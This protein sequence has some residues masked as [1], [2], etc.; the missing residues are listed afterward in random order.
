MVNI[1]RLFPGGNTS[2]G[3][4]S[5]HD[6]IIDIDRNMLYILKGMPGG[7]KSTIM[8]E[9][10]EKAVKEGFSVEFHHCPSDP[11]SI[12]GVVINEL[13]ICVLDG[14]APH[15]IDPVYPG[16]TDKIVDLGPF[17]DSD[18]L[19]LYKSEIFMAKKNNKNAYRSAFNYFRSS[20]PIYDNIEQSNKENVDFANINKLTK[21]A[22][23]RIFSK[24]QILNDVVS[25]KERHLF[26][27]AFTPEG[28]VDYTSTVID[29]VKDRYYLNGSIGTGKTTFLK[30]IAQEAILR[31]YHVEIFHNPLIP[32]KIDSLIIKELNTIISTTNDTKNYIYTTI[33]LDEYFD[34]DCI[35]Q[36]DYQL[37]N[38]I[39]EKG[40]DALHSAKDNHA[41]IESVYKKCINYSGI[42][43]IK[44]KLWEE[45]LEYK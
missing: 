11:N 15:I 3:F 24:E 38:S 1:R 21:N 4:Y 9:I 25:F 17:I 28:F 22:I 5:Y 12:D 10:G 32:N 45:I 29:G 7:G 6:N 2:V 19:K 8:R 26:T 31:N 18:G 42:T 20:K 14:T 41:I 40:I 44:I 13:K 39:I 35:N 27:S 30:R 16:L 36:N 43:E 33:D 37:F 23:E 34:K